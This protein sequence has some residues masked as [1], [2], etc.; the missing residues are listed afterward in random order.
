V[1][2]Q[3]FPLNS[4][5]DANTVVNDF[6]SGTG[7]NF[8]LFCPDSGIAADTCSSGFEDAE[9]SEF[10]HQEHRYVVEA[11]AVFVNLTQDSSV[12]P[13]LSAAATAGA[14]ASGPSLYWGSRY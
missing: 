2:V 6:P 13:L 4:S 3:V 7:W 11:T 12:A 1:S 9:R 14:P 8:G 5:S 10:L